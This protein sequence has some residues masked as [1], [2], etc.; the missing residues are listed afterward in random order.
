M[1]PKTVEYYDWFEDIQP[2]LLKNINEILVSQGIDP[3][4]KFRTAWFKDGK[5]VSISES[6]EYRDFWHVYLDLW[7]KDI[8]ND[9][10]VM[11]YFPEDDPTE[12]EGFRD[13]A[14]K[15]RGEWA[16]VLVDAVR[17]MI[18][19]HNLYKNGYASMLIW[20]SW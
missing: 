11:T 16:V 3:M 13:M 2:E 17:K 14:R 6:A 18:L 4:P 12:W 19:D 8:R 7:G 9:S 15:S 10:Y 1:K 20:F 5:W